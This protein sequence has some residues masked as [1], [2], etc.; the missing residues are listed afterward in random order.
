VRARHGEAGDLRRTRGL[1]H[2]RQALVI[3]IPSEP[4]DYQNPD[5]HRADWDTP[6]IP[7]SWDIVFK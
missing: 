7:Y 4:Y 5:E 3:N 1:A 2:P 6:D